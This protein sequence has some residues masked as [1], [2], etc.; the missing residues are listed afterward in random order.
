MYQPAQGSLGRPSR[1]YLTWVHYMDDVKVM[2]L[3]V[4]E[5]GDPSDVLI[6]GIVNNFYKK[7]RG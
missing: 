2:G 1:V 7:S 5:M 3:G 6:H 4:Q